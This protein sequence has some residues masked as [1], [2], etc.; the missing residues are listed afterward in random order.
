MKLLMVS[1]IHGDFKS[2]EK[3]L[4]NENFD[5][6]VVLGDLFSYGKIILDL[7]NSGLNE[8]CLK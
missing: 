3:V 7:N 8:I 2:L 6:L 4:K 1:D 5:R